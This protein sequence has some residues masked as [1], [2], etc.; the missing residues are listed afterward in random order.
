MSKEPT[1]PTKASP[2]TS[3]W[4]VSEFKQ[5]VEAKVVAGKTLFLVSYDTLADLIDLAEEKFWIEDRLAETDAH[6]NQMENDINDL[7][8][9][10]DQREQD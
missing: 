1:Q 3:R 7:V 5:E 8:K 2:I 6:M 4:D 10:L 9:D